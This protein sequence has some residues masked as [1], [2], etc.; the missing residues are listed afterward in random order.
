MIGDWIVW[1]GVP[2][3]LP[4]HSVGVMLDFALAKPVAHEAYFCI[5]DL[6]RVTMRSAAATSDRTAG[7]SALDGL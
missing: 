5:Q 1:R 2:L 7:H 6:L 4:V 3:A